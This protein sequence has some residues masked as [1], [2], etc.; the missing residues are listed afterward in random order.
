MQG[1]NL[2]AATIRNDLSECSAVWTWGVQ[3][4]KLPPGVNPF[5][6]ISPPKAKK[7][8]KETRAFSKEEAAL[9]LQASRNERGW[10][11]WLSWVLCLTGARLA[12]VVQSQKEDVTTVDG[13]LVLRIHDSGPLRSLKN[14]ESRRDIPLHPALIAEGFLDYV[15]G[16]K[17]RSAL[18]PDIPTDALFGTRSANAAKRSAYWI[19]GLGIKD[20]LI[21]PSHSFRHWF[22]GAARG[23]LIPADVHDALTGHSSKRNEGADYG[24]G[25]KTFLGVLA[26]AMARVP[27]PV[28]SR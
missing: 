13:V 1:R 19:T 4:S 12:E 16:L 15:T 11:R 3:M 18:F 28:P 17:P 10:K 14:Q 20:R 23:A 7:R 2:Q 8:G 24:D 22:K 26:D 25:M 5:S 27:C 6:G 21:S 9:I